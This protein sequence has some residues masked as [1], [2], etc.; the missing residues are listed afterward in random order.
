MKFNERVHAF[1]AAKYYEKLTELDPGRGEAAFIHAIRYYGSQRGRRMAQRAI[2]D[3]RNLTHDVFQE[4]NELIA[5]SGDGV[6]PADGE[7]ISLSP[8]YELHITNCPWHDQFKEM[9]A[10]KAG[11]VYCSLIDEATCGG[12]NPKL[13]FRAESSLNE[14]PYCTH[15]VEK[16]Y[17][18]AYP[19]APQKKEYAHTFDYHCA[20][21]YF[22]CREAVSAILGETGRRA[23]DAVLEDF[24]LTYGEEMKQELCSFE[25]VNFNVVL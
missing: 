18:E 7:L 21:L 14:A 17:Y 15:I 2:A 11:S 23:A 8:D 16:T 10:L 19:D 3:G 6:V 24:A 12:F 9:G 1:I 13:V 5:T 22:S 4:Y 20:H 25:N